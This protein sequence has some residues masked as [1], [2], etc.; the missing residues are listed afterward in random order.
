MKPKNVLFVLLAVVTLTG[1]V[2]LSG[3]AST[4]ISTSATVCF[5]VDVPVSL[6]GIDTVHYK[7]TVCRT[8]DAKLDSGKIKVSVRE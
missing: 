6:N 3:C 5:N 2:L 7:Q 1:S 8:V 4:E